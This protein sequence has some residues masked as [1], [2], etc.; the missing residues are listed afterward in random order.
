MTTRDGDGGAGENDNAWKQH[1]VWSDGK[2]YAVVHFS[3]DDTF[4]IVSTKWLKQ[5]SGKWSTIYPNAEYARNTMKMLIKYASPEAHDL[6]EKFTD[7]ALVNGPAEEDYK[8]SKL[9]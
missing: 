1:L 4:G 9:A 6:I 2:S 8:T 5:E 3:S 7:Y